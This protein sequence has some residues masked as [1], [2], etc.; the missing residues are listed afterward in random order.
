MDLDVLCPMCEDSVMVEE[1]GLRVCHE[2]GHEMSLMEYQI[3]LA[4][5]FDELNTL[6]NTP[7]PS[8]RK[9]FGLK[10]K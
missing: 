8:E 6:L 5:R 10:R 9:S 4:S 7:T 3:Y 2:C 1:N